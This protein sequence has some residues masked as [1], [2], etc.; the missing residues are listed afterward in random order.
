MLSRLETGLRLSGY[1]PGS[2]I[3]VALSGGPDSSALTVGLAELLREGAQIVAA[4]FNHRTRGKESDA[5]EEF[6]RE[7]CADIGIPLQVGHAKN[8]SDG[9]SENDARELR[10]EFLQAI[11]TELDIPYVAVAHTAN[12][13]AET[14]LLRIARGT[15]VQGLAAMPYSR[16]IAVGSE[17]SLIR[18][19]LEATRADVNDYLVGRGIVP[20]DDES[21]RDVRYARNRIRHQVLPVLAEINPAVVQSLTRLAKIARE[22]NDFIEAEFSIAAQL[23]DLPNLNGIQDLAPPLAARLLETMHSEV[24][25][26]GAQLEMNHIEAVLQL[27]KRDKEAELHLPGNVI[28][29]HRVGETTLSRRDGA[30]ASDSA[31]LE[32]AKLPIPGSVV[33]SNGMRMTA[34]V[35]KVPESFEDSPRSGHQCAYISY[36]ND[37]FRNLRDYGYAVVRAREAGDWYEPLGGKG[38]VKVQDLMVNAKIPRSQR[39]RVPI[40]VN[41]Y[42]SW[43]IMWIV[44]FPPGERSRVTDLDKECVKLSVHNPA[45]S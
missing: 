22:H 29:Q 19:L 18:P 39:Y 3:I 9:I 41:P 1:E 20:R 4:H 10:Y 7:L 2:R 45:D 24:A 6:V 27:V 32:E 40:V 12:D 26:S 17:I 31:K 28:L 23:F 36:P 33:L 42:Y 16:P 30:K 35:I 34:E 14:V 38:R 25:E 44:G 43:D 13:Q 11:A 15:G 8:A 5:D 21:N 37:Y